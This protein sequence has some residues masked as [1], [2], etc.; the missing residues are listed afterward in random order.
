MK[1]ILILAALCSSAF[2]QF[3]PFSQVNT[4]QSATGRDWYEIN[5]D[6]LR[7]I[8]PEER[9][10]DAKDIA[11]LIEHY[12]HYVG[13][14]YAVEKPEPF[15]LILRPGM[16]LPNGFV[17]LMPRR[18]EW[19]SHESYIPFIG[20]M[21]FNDALS[22]HEYRHIIQYDFNYQ[23][24]NK[25][26]YLLFGEQGLA[27]MMFAGLP[28]W[29]FEG[30]AVWAETHYTQAGRGRS[31][32]FSARLKALILSGMTP[33]YDEL[34]GRSYNT[35]LPNHYVFG[36]HLIARAYRMF[37][38]DFWQKVVANVT[39]FSINP[40]RI[41]HSF[42][43]I[44][45]VN[46][47]QFVRDTFAELK[48]K[49][50]REGDTLAE[51]KSQDYTRVAHPMIDGN[52][53]YFLKKG[54]NEYWGLYK[55]GSNELIGHFPLLPDYSKTDLKKK[56][57]VYTQYL[58]D[59]RYSFKTYNDLFVYDLTTQETEKW[60][61]N[62]RIYHP[63]WSPSGNQLGFVEYRE[64]GNWSIGI[65]SDAHSK[66]SYFDFKGLKPF[67]L[68]WMSET[69]VYV[70]V[71]NKVGQKSIL[72][73]NL[74]TKKMKEVISDTRNNIYALR[75][76]GS[77]LFFEGDWKGKV[78][79]FKWD[80]SLEVCSNEK[81]A[82]FTP[83]ALGEDL[84]FSV[85][86]AQGQ[87]MKKRSLSQCSPVLLS[88]FSGIERL[89]KDSPSDQA[90]AATTLT[91]TDA[92]FKK[93]YSEEEY[94]DTLGGMSP[95]SWSFV[96]DAGYQIGLMGNNY[97]G[98]LGWSAAI[99]YD[100]EQSKPFANLSLSY[101]KFFPIFSAYSSLRRREY[102]YLGSNGPDL[103]WT[104]TEV[105]LKVT[106]PFQW[107]RGFYTHDLKLSI[108]GGLIK[109]SPEETLANVSVI[110]DQLTYQSAE[111][112][113]LMSKELT[114][115]QIY[116]PWALSLRGFYRNAKSDKRSSFDSSILH[117][118]TNV[119]V[120]GL[121]ENHGIKLGAYYEK[122][123]TG[124]NNYRHE[125][126]EVTA[127]EYSLSRGY[128]YS[129]VDSFTKFTIDYALPVMNPDLDLWGWAYLRRLYI[130]PFYDY[131]DYKI[132]SYQGTLQSYGSEIY[133]ETNLFRRL[134]LTLGGRYSYRSEAGNGVWDIILG[135]NFTY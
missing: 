34:I 6:T 72:Q 116:S 13:K 67:E 135:S 35:N 27:L 1:S 25:F 94:S 118:R 23:S 86:M 26:A 122:Q 76:L 60:S 81:I 113:W 56:R 10:E 78:Q 47:D 58:P 53:I 103:D 105:G 38:D 87:R 8:F 88:E 68:A 12:S 120:P 50:E 42:E 97:L 134:P 41:Y 91:I 131:T 18:S 62:K 117:A 111:F 102:D 79:A 11:N 32:R 28:S 46:F 21:S 92:L 20:G 95:H 9:R 69:E 40:Y 45:G 4:S 90:T 110:E 16:S 44:S 73:V 132:L 93:D 109:A 99:G 123:T 22:I 114:Y 126:V 15:P 37:G 127:S 61:E 30:D 3:T 63:Q 54:L 39:R 29:Y 2:A 74:E 112:S 107:V 75:A 77:T 89:S 71:Q 33:T 125:P 51:T 52:D 101:T 49:W 133:F 57:F 130:V 55:K 17:T 100:S 64:E 19:F 82:A 65:K 24:T 85:E 7:L 70:L 121:F 14:S 48:T 84:Y 128:N 124:L 115:Q 43:K 96:G 98:T 119:Y 31:P 129:Y 80:K 104:E 83:I 66:T 36:Y 108:D 106:L 5:T 59:L